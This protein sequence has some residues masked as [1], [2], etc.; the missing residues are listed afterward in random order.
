MPYLIYIV[1]KDSYNTG[2]PILDEQHRGLVSI[3]NS[4]FFHRSDPA[5]GI[6]KMLVVTAD[7]FK[8]YV[9]IN[10]LTIEKLMAQSSYPKLEEYQL[11]HATIIS[12]IDVMEAKFRKAA[13]GQG[14]LEFIK[15]Y[16]FTTIENCKKEYI[17]HI[18]DYYKHNQ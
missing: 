10:L 8:A 3:I 11:L 18:V 1:W 15:S 13:D 12:K 5:K 14:F 2:I 6:D 7:M 4:F 17:P 9:K 16:W